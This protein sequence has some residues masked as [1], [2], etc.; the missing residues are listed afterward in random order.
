MRR[1]Q[2]MDNSSSMNCSLRLLPPKIDVVQH[3]SSGSA[4]LNCVL[5]W[6]SHAY[7]NEKV[8]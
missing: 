3:F 2:K 8:M 1:V 7:M 6:T 5:I 4:A